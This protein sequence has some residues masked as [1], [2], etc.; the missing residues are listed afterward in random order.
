MTTDA[1]TDDV[2]DDAH[3]PPD[4]QVV[5]VCTPDAVGR[6]TGK[7]IAAA[8]WPQVLTR[9]LPMPDFHLATDLPGSIQPDLE[10]T[11]AHTG[12]PNGLLRPDPSTLRR[13]PWQ[14]DHAL[15]ICDVAD[16]A[17]TAVRESP[18]RVLADQVHRLRTAGL[19]A[20]VATELELY[21]YAESGSEAARAGY[22]GL[23]PLHH[24]AGDHDIL[25]ASQYEA[26]L[27]P[28]RSAMDALGH[29]VISTLGE[30][31]QGQ[32][33]INFGHGSP[34]ATADAH[35]VFKL[36]AKALAAQAGLSVTFM[37]KPHDDQPG[38]S[39]HI[40]LSLRDASHG[41]A[42]FE[43]ADEPH[44]LDSRA[45]SFLAGITAHVSDFALLHAPYTNS[46]RRLRSGN[47][48]PERATWAVDDRRALVRLLGSGA[49]G[50][51]E[52]RYPGADANPYLSLAAVLAAGMAGLDAGLDPESDST[53]A[54]LPLDLRDAVE[55]FTDSHAAR[56]AFGDDVHTHL[57]A[58]GRHEWR[59]T[60]PLVADW[61]RRRGFEAV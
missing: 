29:P 41:T 60:E 21:L 14:P 28:L 50:R 30:G 4:V 26:F 15:V 44:R 45:R 22:A 36:T 61:E 57:A 38:S 58:R 1:A 16:S 51:L 52:F 53:G 8:D 49:S 32:L 20:S 59:S 3:L 2:P 18:R 43:H 55:C 35:V 7:S 24:R 46:F 19:D 10:V 11:G 42:L 27:G 13:L 25:V 48:V 23:T 47:W 6:L 17:G 37:A 40:H 31:G 5:V 12:F 39:G 54:G 34:V 9:G 33:E 56:K